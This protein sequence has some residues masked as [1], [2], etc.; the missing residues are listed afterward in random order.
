M[1]TQS[2]GG[3]TV[4]KSVKFILI[5]AVLAAIVVAFSLFQKQES[6]QPSQNQNSDPNSFEFKPL[7]SDEQAALNAPKSASEPEEVVNAHAA[8]VRRVAVATNTVNVGSGCRTSPTA[9]EI[10]NGTNI[11]FIN[12]D[13]VPHTIS[14]NASKNV[15]IPANDQA[16]ITVDFGEKT[17]IYGYGCESSS[18]PIGMVLIAE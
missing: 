7:T 16:S 1:E 11:T 6:G 15:V 18:S 5:I 12:R 17:R 3:D 14:F 13:S 10:A 8:A 9:V 4:G 2:S